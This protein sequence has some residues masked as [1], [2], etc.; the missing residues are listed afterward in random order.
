MHLLAQQ[1]ISATPKTAIQLTSFEQA[2][3]SVQVPG[4]KVI[5]SEGI[6]T[7]RRVYKLKTFLAA[8]EFANQIST[9]AE[10]GDHHPALLIE[11]GRVTVTWWSHSIGGLHL[12][13]FVMAAKTDEIYSTL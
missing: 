7:L 9:I 13:D 11:W 4:W 10:Q 5:V 1:N 12:N 6:E 3:L 2:E 8:M